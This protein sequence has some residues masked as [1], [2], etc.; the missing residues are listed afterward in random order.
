MLPVDEMAAVAL[1]AGVKRS[2]LA[3]RSATPALSIFLSFIIKF[4]SFKFEKIIYHQK[5]HFIIIINDKSGNLWFAKLYI[6]KIEKIIYN[7]KVT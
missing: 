7:T 5:S 1:M 6:G 2:K 3:L 4:P